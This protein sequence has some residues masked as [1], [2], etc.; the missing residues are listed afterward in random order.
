MMN[1]FLILFGIFY[2]AEHVSSWALTWLNLR[3]LAEHQDAVPEYF[4]DKI[5]LKD[6]QKGLRY[7]R[8]K[9]HLGIISSLAE[10]PIFWGMLLA[11]G[12]NAIDFW[13]RSWHG[14]S[15]LTGLF[16]LGIM[17]AFFY[18]VSLPYDL[19]STFSIEQRFGFNKI[20]F[21]L[22]LSDLIKGLVLTLVVGG[23]VLVATLWFMNKYAGKPWWFYVWILLAVVQ[24]FVVSLYPVLIVPLFNKL[25]PLPDGTL[26]GK[27]ENLAHRACFQMKGIFVMDG[28][29]RSSHSNAFFAGMGRFRRII[30]FDTLIQSLSEDELVGVLAHEMGHY[31]KKHTRTTMFINLA[32]S[33]VGLYVLAFLLKAPWFYQAFGFSLASS[34]AALFIFAST[35]GA[36]LFFIEPFFSWISRRNEYA[37]DR[38][39]AQITQ[40]PQELVRA[41]IKLTRDNLSNLTP[42][43]LYSFFYYSHPTIMERIENLENPGP[44]QD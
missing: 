14:G 37:A 29:K 16:F 33:L 27:I 5:T 11:G 39:A 28:S 2:F 32:F 10:I 36:F 3:H 31:L 1:R 22:W 35:S 19:Y 20:T 25:S 7:T 41:L 13:S 18:L 38:F 26:R 17:A 30:L 24:L 43:P 21:R 44:A 15:I 4:L 23:L 12:F 8:E 40:T 6:Y 9:A 34:Q 42:H